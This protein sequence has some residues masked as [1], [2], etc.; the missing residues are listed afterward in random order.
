MN[1]NAFA[2]NPPFCNNYSKEFHIWEKGEGCYLEDVDGKKFLDF[3]SGIAVNSLGYGRKD[4]ARVMAEQA[5][6]LIHIS[7]LY[8]SKPSLD[9]A[10]KLTGLGDFEAVHFGNSGS[11]ANEAA[12]KYSRIFA[13]RTKGDGV[14]KYLSFS[15]AFHGRTAGALSVT[16]NEKYHKPYS[17]LLENCVVCEFNNVE[18]LENTLDESFA[19]VIVEPIQGEGGLTKASKEFCQTLNSLCEKFSVVLIADEIQTGLGRTGYT[20]ASNLVGLKPDI[21]TLAKPLAGG[22][23]LSATLIPQKINTLIQVGDH[24]TT[25]GGGPVTCAVSNYVLDKILDKDFLSD[26]IEKGEYLKSKLEELKDEFSFITE[27]RGDG[28]M[29]GIC[30]EGINPSDIVKL[31][32]ENGLLILRSGLNVVRIL[33]PLIIE[34]SEIDEGIKILKKIFKNIGV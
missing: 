2:I 23:P 11:E 4:L 8:T 9:L 22:L 12:L 1:K 31:A 6:K 5:E 21:I 18:E 17:P 33:P 24:G 28:L 3:G 7:N 10:K 13:K 14:Y 27:L 32:E 15:S 30:L 20:F 34:K 29:Q 19:A 25:F 16:P 26:V